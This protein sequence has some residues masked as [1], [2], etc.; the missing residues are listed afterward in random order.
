MKQLVMHVDMDAFFASVEQ[1]DHEEY[2]G[3]PLIIGGLAGRGVV[4]TCSYEARK[5]GVHSAMPMGRAQQLCPQG[6]FIEGN[7]SR[8]AEV[9]QQ[10]FAVFDCYSPV[11]EPLSIDEAFLDLTGMEKI[12]GTPLG[13]ARKLKGEIRE[14]TGIVASVG[15][16]PNKFLA[17]LAS[18]LE[19]PDGLVII[20]EDKIRQVLDPLPVRRIWGVGRRMNEQLEKLGIQTIGQL[21]RADYH[22][23]QQQVGENMARHLH[24]LAAGIDHRIVAPRERAKS[25][26]KEMTFT[27]D[28]QCREDAERVLLDLSCKVGW[29]LRKAGEKARTIQLKL[30][31]SSGFKT[32]TRSRTLSEATCYDEEIYHTVLDLLHEL[33][34]FR[35]IR[36]LGVSTAGFDDGRELNLFQDEGKKDN[37]YAAID[38]IRAKFGEGGITKAQLLCKD[39][40]K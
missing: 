7:Y 26:G 1:L 10:I 32:Y 11:I 40:R 17:K 9:S 4:S 13:Y 27:E 12:M 28:L 33:K 3:K 19:K 2:R 14:K 34:L 16:A 20:T 25:I 18:D 35:G 23:L 21:Y 15:I 36:L 39:K 31:L 37:L 8:Y 6:I 30:R 5:F 24:Q 38:K 22:R 29:R